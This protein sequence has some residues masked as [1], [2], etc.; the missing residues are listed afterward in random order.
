MSTTKS[1]SAQTLANAFPT[2]SNT[3]MDEQSLGFQFF[4]SLGRKM[5]DIRKQISIIGDNY[6]LMSS[7]L[8]DIDI[9]YSVNL[10]GTYV[11]DTIDDDTTQLSFVAPTV[12]GLYD[13]QWYPVSLAEENNIESF[14]YTTVP[15]RLTLDDSVD[16]EHLLASG[17]AQNSPFYPLTSSG[18]GHIPNQLTID[19]SGGTSYVG[20]EGQFTVRRGIIQVDGVNRQGRSIVEEIPFLH[21]EKIKTRNE[22]QYL[23]SPGVRAYGIK[24]EDEAFITVSSADFFSEDVAVNYDMDQNQ[25][26]QESSMFFALETTASGLSVLA[27]KKYD[28]DDIELRMDGFSGK[29]T[30]IQQHL[31]DASGLAVSHSDIA[32]EPHT[33]KF[34]TVADNWLHVYDLDFPYP[35]T[36]AFRKKDYDASSY[37]QPSTYYAVQYDEVD[38]DYIWARPTTGMVRHRAWVEKPDGTKYSIIGGV[39][40]AYITDRDSWVYEEA[41]SKKIRGTETYQLDQV[42][43]YLYSFEVGYTDGTSSIDQKIVLVLAK[44]ARASYELA[45]LGVLLA[46]GIDFDSE[47]N[48][49]VLAAGGTKYKIGR[50]Y[51]TML[52]DTRRKTIYTREPYS[53]V[54]VF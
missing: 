45:P 42:G 13:G 44:T 10:P 34:W 30:I 12:S 32:I 17:F 48:L 11:F 33:D 52:I 4:N 9:Y 25:D 20:I 22:F 28:T 1:R 16:G 18:F 19:I 7:R 38:F 24:N 51:D 40:S 31:L 23:N 41:D 53:Q 29:H 54:R 46:S 26:R 43:Q 50:H 49:W 21:D 6:F 35:D 39:E 37:I 3:R 2:W 36:S 5:E 15:D 14:W 47:S 27:V 8:N